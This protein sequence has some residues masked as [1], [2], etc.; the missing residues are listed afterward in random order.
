MKL[1]CFYQEASSKAIF[2]NWEKSLQTWFCRWGFSVTRLTYLRVSNNWKAHFFCS[3]MVSATLQI[4]LP[5]ILNPSLLNKRAL[6]RSEYIVWTCVSC[7]L[8]QKPVALSINAATEPCP[9]YYGPCAPAFPS[10]L[11][12]KRTQSIASTSDTWKSQHAN[13]VQK[14]RF[15]TLQDTC[16]IRS[17]CWFCM[18]SPCGV[19]LRA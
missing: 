13:E 2:E 10:P 7:G 15:K 11:S 17:K 16:C 12:L 19:G 18:T 9:P 8:A 14:S 5:E 1:K 3:A 6:T 4:S